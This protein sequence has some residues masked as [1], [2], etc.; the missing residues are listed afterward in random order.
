MGIPPTE[1]VRLSQGTHNNRA[2]NAIRPF[3]IG[4]KNWL[5]SNSVAGVKAS[6]NLYSLIETAKANGVEP[7]QYLRHVF[8]ELPK[9]T[10][11]ED[12]EQLLP[13]NTQSRQGCG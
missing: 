6:A 7:Y 3:A 4:R 9:V 10:T 12:I 11:V 13:W 8:T 2:E 1:L 5:F